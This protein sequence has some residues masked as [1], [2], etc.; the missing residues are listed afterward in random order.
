MGAQAVCATASCL[1][2]LVLQRIMVQL[3]MIVAL[4]GEAGLHAVKADCSS[5]NL[6]DTIPQG[7]WYE[8]CCLQ[9]D[10]AQDVSYYAKFHSVNNDQYTITPVVADDSGNTG[11]CSGSASGPSDWKTYNAQSYSDNFPHEEQ[12][13]L[14]QSGGVYV[15]TQISFRILCTKPGSG[16]SCQISVDQLHLCS[17]RGCGPL[18]NRKTAAISGEYN[19]TAIKGHGSVLS[20]QLVI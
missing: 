18:A 6:Q 8:H 12:Y 1:T 17:G 15:H 5:S 20:N 19:N 9:M 13:Y 14:E 4:L 2:Q 16:D 11:H 7:N 10:G 3:W